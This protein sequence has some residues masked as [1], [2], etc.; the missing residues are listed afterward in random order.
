MMFDLES[1]LFGLWAGGCLI[2][3][4]WG[5]YHSGKESEKKKAKQ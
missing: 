5:I 4:L 1:F 3:S 2:I